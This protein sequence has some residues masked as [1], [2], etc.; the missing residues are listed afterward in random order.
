MTEFEVYVYEFLAR[1]AEALERQAAATEKL[2]YP[3]REVV[4]I[5]EEDGL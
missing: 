1:I 5:P 2:A 3:L 4:I